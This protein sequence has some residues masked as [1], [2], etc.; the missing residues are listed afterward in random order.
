MIDGPLFQSLPSGP[1]HDALTALRRDLLADGGPRIS[2]MRNHRYAI[3]VYP[4]EREFELRRAVASLCEELRAQ[5]WS[6][7]ELSLQRLLLARLRALP[8]EDR[9]RIA[10]REQRFAVD[11]GDPRRAMDF[12]K[13]SLGPTLEGPAGVA[14]DVARALDAFV[15]DR[16]VVE[17]RAVV[18]L[19]R[20]SALYPFVRASSLLKHIAGRTHHLP[21]ILLYPGTAQDRG[22]SFLGEFTA[23]RDYRPRLYP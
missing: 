18:F 19:S 5:Q 15:E 10:S 17:D 11:K 20:V 23:D 22:L 12:L 3:W 16:S 9:A 21:V 4:P 7:L 8:A 13:E 1:V 6:T 2:T 14:G